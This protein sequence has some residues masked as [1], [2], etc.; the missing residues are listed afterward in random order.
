MGLLDVYE[1]AQQM[2]SEARLRRLL[3]LRAML[4]DKTQREVAADL[5]ISQSALSQRLK[6]SAALD[7]VHPAV[8]LRAAAPVLK[9]LAESR[10]YRRLSVFG[11]VARGEA[12][13]DSD[14]DVLVEAPEGTSSFAF[15][16][17]KSLL[18]QVLGRPIDLASFGGLQEQHGP[19]QREAVAL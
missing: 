9:E 12:S 13:D 6:G 4:V 18:E 19:I 11:S 15:L 10:D 7:Q 16:R 17:F 3:A 14:I 5:G 2:E 8:L 1:A